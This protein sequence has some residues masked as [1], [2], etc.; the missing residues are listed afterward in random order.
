MGTDYP[1]YPTETTVPIRGLN[2]SYTFLH[3]TDL[4][5]CAFSSEEAES[6]PRERVAYIT[7]RVAAFADGIP[8]SDG[9]LTAARMPAFFDYADRRHADLILMTGDII[10]FPSE[11]NIRLLHNCMSSAAT[12]GLYTLGNHDWSF[13]DDYHTA[14]AQAVNIPRFAAICGGDTRLHT[15]EYPDLIVAAV[16]DSR[17]CIDEQTLDAFLKLEQHAKNSAKPIMLICHIPLRVGTLDED[18]IRTWRSN[19]TL[20]PTA[21]GRNDPVTLAFYREVAERADTPVALVAAGHV[22]FAHEDI[23]PNGVPQLVT[24]VANGG[25]CRMIRLVPARG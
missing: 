21:L 5:A 25:A 22:H 24:P 3:V 4:H 12:P 16:D 18:T 2:K 23:L 17:D 10:D 15:V 11:A 13:A 7:Q 8:T 19:I 1:V 14:H 20:G 6:M 9:I